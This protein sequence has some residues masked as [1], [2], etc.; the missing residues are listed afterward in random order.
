MP[1]M[2][3]SFVSSKCCKTL[4]NPVTRAPQKIWKSA[5]SKNNFLKQRSNGNEPLDQPQCDDQQPPSTPK[6]LSQIVPARCSQVREVS[7]APRSEPKGFGVALNCGATSFAFD[8]GTRPSRASIG[9]PQPPIN[10]TPIPSCLV[11]FHKGEK[12]AAR[13]REPRHHGANRHLRSLGNLTVGH[14]M[15]IS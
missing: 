6:Q 11:F 9:K 3:D 5:L 1:P 10:A 8:T 12:P 7:R 14:S 4:G 13:P 15:K 2:N